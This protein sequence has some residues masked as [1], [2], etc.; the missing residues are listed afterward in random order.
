RTPITPGSCPKPGV[1][2]GSVPLSR[3]AMPVL[4]ISS[5]MNSTVP[6]STRNSPPRRAPDGLCVMTVLHSRERRA[7]LERALV[8]EHGLTVVFGGATSVHRDPRAEPDGQLT[9]RDE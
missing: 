2:I 5:A 4:K 3:L 6:I 8:L 7:G 9:P 1:S